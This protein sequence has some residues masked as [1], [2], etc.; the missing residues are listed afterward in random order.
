MHLVIAVPRAGQFNVYEAR[1]SHVDLGAYLR[2]PGEPGE[3][4]RFARARSGVTPLS[5]ISQTSAFAQ[6]LRSGCRTPCT[7]A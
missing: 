3:R 6:R 1:T 4:A 7:P 2:E 5:A